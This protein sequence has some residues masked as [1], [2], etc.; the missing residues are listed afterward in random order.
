M[1]DGVLREFA[2]NIW[3]GQLDGWWVQVSH[4]N[5]GW[6]LAVGHLSRG[7]IRRCQPVRSFGHGTKLARALIEE[8]RPA[9]ER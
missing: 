1:R 7:H 2:P 9:R 8:W 5:T 6:T 4:Y 3:R